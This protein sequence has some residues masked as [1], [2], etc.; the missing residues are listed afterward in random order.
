MI[1]TV[2]RTFLRTSLRN[3]NRLLGSLFGRNSD[4]DL[5]ESW[6]RIS[7]CWLKKTFAAV[8]RQKK[9]IGAPDSSSAAPSRRRRATAISAVC[10]RSI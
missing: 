1:R 8:S 5:A 6:I 2:F 9:H 10:Q 4:A 7:T 3:W